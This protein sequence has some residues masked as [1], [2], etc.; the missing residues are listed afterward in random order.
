MTPADTFID[1][2]IKALVDSD[3][4]TLNQ[5]QEKSHQL[6]S[7]RA[8]A[9]VHLRMHKLRIPSMFKIKEVDNA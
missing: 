3:V 6:E 8:I 7:F 9:K 1:S 4:M 5:I 2:I